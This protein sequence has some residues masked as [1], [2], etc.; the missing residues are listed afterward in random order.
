MRVSNALGS[1]VRYEP[2]AT[3]QTDRIELSEIARLAEVF[4]E[5]S[6]RWYAVSDAT[7]LSGRITVAVRYRA[8]AWAYE[9]AARIC[10][11]QLAKQ[12]AGQ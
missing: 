4:R 7:L 9:Q 10:Q 6:A 11:E 3:P 5:T 8:R 2:S 1:N 12:E